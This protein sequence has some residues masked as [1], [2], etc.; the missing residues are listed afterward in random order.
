MVLRFRGN[1]LKF[2]I[3]LLPLQV[4]VFAQIHGNVS[5]GAYLFA[6][7]NSS[8][9][10][11]ASGDFALGFRQVENHHDLFLLC[12]WYAKIPDKTIIWYANGD[13]PAP[14]GSKL[15]LAADRGLLLTCPQGL[16]LW[17]SETILDEVAYGVMSNDGNFI[18]EDSNSNKLWQT[19]EHPTNTLLP[20]QIMQRGGFL[21]SPHS[22]TNYSKGRFQLRL[23]ADG[24]LVLNTINLPTEFANEPYYK[25]GTTGERNSWTTAGIQLVYN[26]SGSMY[27]L[28]ENNERF[29]LTQGVVSARDY[30][31]RATLNFDG[32]F[33]QYFHRK[34]FT[35]NA[36][37]IPLWS[38]PENICNSIMVYG[39]VGVC[40]YN[41]I[42]SLKVDQRP[43]CVCPK[44]YSL[45]DPNDVYGSCKPDFTQSCAEKASSTKDQYDVVELTNT[46]WPTS[47]YIRLFPVTAEMC[48]ESCLLDCMCFVAIFEDGTCSKKKLPLSNGRVDPKRNTIAFIKM[49]KENHTYTFSTPKQPSSHEHHSPPH[50]KKRNKDA[51]IRVVLALLGTSLFVNLILI[52]ASLLKYF[53]IRHKKRKPFSQIHPEMNLLS[54]TYEE[55][56]QATNGFQEELGRGAFGTVFKGVLAFEDIN[57]VA[58]KKLDNMVR[59][60]GEEEFKAEVNAIGRTDHKNLV[61]LVGFCKEGQHRLLVYE[62]MRNGSLASF[63]FGPHHRPNWRLRIQMALGT[64]KGLFYLH[65]DCSNQIIHCDIKPQNILLDESFTARISDFGLAKILKTN[66]TRTTTGIR[67]TKGY[68]APEWFR[69]KPVTSKVDV[70][71]YGILLLEIIFCRKNFEAKVEDESQMVLADWA[72]DCFIDGKL[73]LLLQGDDEALADLNRV[74]KY[75]MVAIWCIQENPSLRPSMK[76]VARML[77]GIVEVSIPPDPSSSTKGLW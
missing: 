57:L 12:I 65:E 21:S 58:V 34:D 10:L 9:W 66:Q 48:K 25:S 6:A 7:N 16:E 53:F 45:L 18:L 27:V 75:V 60:G 11:S 49:P 5:V 28:R 74:E 1:I 44:G 51:L 42:C 2:F 17:K 14:R 47:D 43:S 24:N 23:L 69:N 36:S 52:G 72:Y 19:F 55:L 67:G 30:Y 29:N 39:G 13:Q 63:L 40:G 32:I 8:T 62:F 15:S 76:K 64:A 70:Y 37:W 50:G 35:G 41:S 22:E 73:N 3:F 38:I 54:F 61:R 68:V 56:E 46:V 31:F 71:S 4:C 20:T 26:Q 77:E 33:T 59:E